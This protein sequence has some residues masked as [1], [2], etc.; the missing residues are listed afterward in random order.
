VT[1]G[2][3]GCQ[4]GDFT[5]RHTK[6]HTKTSFDSGRPFALLDGVTLNDEQTP[7]VTKMTKIRYAKP[8]FSRLGLLRHLTRLS[9]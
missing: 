7:G 5:G 4:A 8:Q 2:H 1:C 9:F 3:E 6:I